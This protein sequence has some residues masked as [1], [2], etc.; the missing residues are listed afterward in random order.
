M[1]SKWEKVALKTNLLYAKQVGKGCIKN[2]PFETKTYKAYAV[3]FFCSILTPD[4]KRNCN[5]P[6]AE[7]PPT[8]SGIAPTTSGIAPDCKR[9]CLRK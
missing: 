5:R 9:N 3:V 7:L 6:Q 2:Q 1:R 4:C 8:T